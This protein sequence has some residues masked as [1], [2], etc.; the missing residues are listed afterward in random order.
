MRFPFGARPRLTL[1]TLMSTRLPGVALNL[2]PT[3]EEDEHE[4][5]NPYG[6]EFAVWVGKGCPS[7]VA[8]TSMS[9]VSRQYIISRSGDNGCDHVFTITPGSP[10]T[11]PSLIVRNRYRKRC[12]R[13]KALQTDSIKRPERNILIARSKRCLRGEPDLRYNERA[14]DHTK[15][16][17]CEA[18]LHGKTEYS[19]D[20]RGGSEIDGRCCQNT[21]NGTS[22]SVIPSFI[23]AAGC[24]AAGRPR[25]ALRIPDDGGSCE[26]PS[27]IPLPAPPPPA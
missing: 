4:T 13:V 20:K 22:S 14:S 11:S 10:D 19:L 9:Q 25:G 1:S 17:P 7:T 15:I 8:C 18:S 2:T 6:A 27:S 24:A 23:D 26:N 3:G 16:K 12:A 21:Q 5:E